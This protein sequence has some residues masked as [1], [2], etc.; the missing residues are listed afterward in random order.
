MGVRGGGG[1][2]LKYCQ[3]FFV[4]SVLFAF[5]HPLHPVLPQKHVIDPGHSARCAGGRLQLDTHVP[6]VNWCIVA[7]CIENVGQDG[8]SLTWHQPCNNQTALYR[9]YFGGRRC[10]TYS[11]SHATRTQ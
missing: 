8:S 11:E 10:I 7:R 2:W 4:F 5:R 3:I 6:Y 1:A 9:Y